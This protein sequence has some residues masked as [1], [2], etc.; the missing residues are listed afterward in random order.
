MTSPSTQPPVG[1]PGGVPK[2]RMIA[3]AIKA[4][5]HT[6][7]TGRPCAYHVYM[8][9]CGT[10]LMPTATAAVCV[11]MHCTQCGETFELDFSRSFGDKKKVKAPLNSSPWDK[12]IDTLK[13]IAS[14]PLHWL[15][16]G[17]LVGTHS[18]RIQVGRLENA[19]PV[20]PQ[21]VVPSHLC[22]YVGHFVHWV[23]SAS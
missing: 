13:A 7:K 21:M 2:E 1:I 18:R 5:V 19:A 4:R 10:N 22:L 8:A 6:G 23:H 11:L 17:Q 15:G 20:G 12:A 16:A 14:A 9:G 3:L